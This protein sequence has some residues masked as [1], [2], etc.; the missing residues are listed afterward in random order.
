[1]PNVSLT[2]PSDYATQ[3]A[4]IERRR[5]MAE[6]LSQQSMQPQEQQTAGGMTVPTSWTQ[7]AAKLFQGYLGGQG[8]A[9]ATADSKALAAA[10]RGDAQN[11]MGTMPQ[12]TPASDKLAGDPYVA[13][14]Q[15]NVHT[16]AKPPS[17]QDSMAWAMRGAMSGN[18]YTQQLSQMLLPHMLKGTEPFSLREGEIRVGGNGEQIAA[19]PKQHPLHFTDEGGVIQPRD[20]MKGAAVGAP[21][22]KSFTP[23][24]QERHD[25]NQG[26]GPPYELGGAMVRRNSITGKVEQVVAR[27]PQIHNNNPAP[28]TAVTIADP[29]DPNKTIVVDGRTGKKIGDGPKLTQTGAADQKL[30]L[31]KPQA[32]L[33][34]EAMTQNLDRLDTAMTALDKDPGLSNITGTVMGRTPN[35]TNKATGAQAQLNSIKSQIFVDALQAM[36]EASK[37]GGAVGNVSD[38][39]GDKL[40]RTLAALDQ[41]QSTADFRKQM[42]KGQEQ[43]RISRQLIHNAYEEQYGSIPDMNPGA[44]SNAAPGGAPQASPQRRSTDKPRVVDW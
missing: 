25:E 2:A 43:L 11:F 42:R 26:W 34:V 37:T 17:S 8:Q 41:A 5:K 40:E 22:P 39:E 20:P 36:R 23:D 1:M 27:P 35:L 12:G 4:D 3:Q 14:D 32:K 21:I 44:P 19:N 16:P 33:R 31:A 7:H 6:I 29:S 28:V 24:Q 15:M 30:T 18:P 38:R 13:D 10:M 9:K